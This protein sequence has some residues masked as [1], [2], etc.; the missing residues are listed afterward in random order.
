MY[1]LPALPYPYD[2]L[3]PVISAAR[4]G[5]TTTSITPAT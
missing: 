2:A 5:S 4:C 3:E 1:Q